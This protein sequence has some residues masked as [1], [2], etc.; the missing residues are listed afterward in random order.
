M[1]M[2]K[3]SILIAARNE[4][5][6]QRTINSA[7]E[8][9]EGEVEVI[10]VL[11]GYRPEIK[12]HK[13]LTLI[14]HPESIGQ[15]PAINQAAALAT[16][17]YIFKVDAHCIFDEGYDVKLSADCDYDWTTVPTRHGVREDKWEKRSGRV[18]YMRMTSPSE[19]GDF[20]LR[21]AAWYEYRERPC[22]KNVL[23]DIMILQGSGWFLHKK[24]FWELGGLD[25]KHGHWGAMGCEIACKTWLSGGRLVRNKKTWYAHWQ[26]GRRHS[27][28]GS[29]SRFYYLPRQ[30]IRDAHEYAKSL[31]FLNRWPLQ[32]RKF[33]WILDK[34]APVPFWREG[35]PEIDDYIRKNTRKVR[36]A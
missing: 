6:L 17:K 31:W 23:D 7:F 35:Y 20:G 26:R 19:R 33:T 21:A 8:K 5:Y 13:N 34:F 30:V 11:D 25:E 10:A 1:A 12:D 18:N 27:L 29:T 2:D 22:A 15:R 4:P 24:R 16:G 9:A 14:Y 28:A 3:V 32:V 36:C